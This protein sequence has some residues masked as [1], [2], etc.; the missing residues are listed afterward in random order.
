M[1]CNYHPNQEAKSI[2]EKCK[3]PIC[4]ECTINAADRTICRHCLQQTLNVE[5]SMLPR[6]T[7]LEKF[8]FFCFSLI[9]GAAHMHMGLFRRGFQ[10]MLLTFG[11]ISLISFMGLDFLIPL[12]LIPT[13]FFSFFESYHLRNQLEKGQIPNDL[14]LISHQVLDYSTLLKN[15]RLVGAAICAIGFLSL[16]RELDRSS[17]LDR[18]F[19]NH[20]YLLRG[21]LFPLCLILGGIYLI[22]KAKRPPKTLAD[23]L[24]SEM[25]SSNETEHQDFTSST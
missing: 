22:I 10:F 8:L 23:S 13:W 9:P 15:R 20:Y 2:C 16:M 25:N 1:N 5:P 21:S 7:F 14:D 11:G 19:G 3:K 17:L 18:L 24:K 6:K 4:P 12:V